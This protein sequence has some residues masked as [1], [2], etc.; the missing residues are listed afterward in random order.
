M[1]KEQ[2]PNQVDL[3]SCRH[4][5]LQGWERPFSCLQPQASSTPAPEPLTSASRG[6]TG[7][8]VMGESLLRDSA[9]RVIRQEM[10]ELKKTMELWGCLQ[11][12]ESV[13]P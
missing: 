13:G 10:S 1:G 5:L 3:L 11:P 6:D 12:V 9:G 7:A 2:G 4:V 8:L